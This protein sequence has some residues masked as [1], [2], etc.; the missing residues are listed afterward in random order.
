MNNF[1]Y[2]NTHALLASA[3]Q[4]LSLLNPLI[5]SDYVQLSQ[6]LLQVHHTK[7]HGEEKGGT[8]IPRPFHR[9]HH[10]RGPA[11]PPDSLHP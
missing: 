10:V 2:A 9:D 7:V 6:E 8:V 3:L 1:T 5:Y 11:Q 4:N